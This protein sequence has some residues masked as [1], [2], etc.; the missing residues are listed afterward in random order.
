MLTQWSIW[1]LYDTGGAV[2]AYRLSI[3]Y[4]VLRFV[5]TV[6]FITSHIYARVPDL[7]EYVEYKVNEDLIFLYSLGKAY[8]NGH[9][10]ILDNLDNLVTDKAIS[11]NLELK[12]VRE[13]QE[14]LRRLGQLSQSHPWV[15]ITVK[16]KDVTRIVLNE[17]KKEMDDMKTLGKLT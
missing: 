15:V 14:I 3:L 4:V 13:K 5:R 10:E 17:T 9:D 16:T 8:I 6:Y 11:K 1:I 12:L 2:R 7:R